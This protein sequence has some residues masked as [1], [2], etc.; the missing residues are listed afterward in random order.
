M[1]S[2]LIDSEVNHYPYGSSAWEIIDSFELDTDSSISAGTFESACRI[3]TKAFVWAP[4]VRCLVRATEVCSKPETESAVNDFDGR[5]NAASRSMTAANE[6]K[7]DQAIRQAGTTAPRNRNV[8]ER[9]VEVPR[10][11]TATGS[12]N[13]WQSSRRHS[14]TACGLSG[15]AW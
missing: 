14:F 2:L 6:S 9:C 13:L 12:R 8:C 10:L 4:D 7:S 5:G 11:E 3:T 15:T 1:L